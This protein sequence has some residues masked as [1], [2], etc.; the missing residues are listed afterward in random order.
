MAFTTAVL[1][2]AVDGAT[3]ILGFASL[4]T[5]DPGGTGANEVAGGGY[6]RIAA[7]WDPATGAIGAL[8]A[9]L[10]FSGPANGAATHIGF[11]SAISAGTW[12]GGEALTGDQTF[13]AAGDYTVTAVT[14]TGAN[15]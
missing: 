15:D 10:N 1:N 14:V 8:D 2:A 9:A 13:N 7:V 6:T 5:A 3:A 11:W 12:R 4:H